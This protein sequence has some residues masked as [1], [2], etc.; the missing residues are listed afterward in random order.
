MYCR[1]RFSVRLG[2]QFIFEKYF[3]SI[4]QMLKTSYYFDFKN[5]DLYM[6]AYDDVTDRIFS[7]SMLID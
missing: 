5:Q 2:N 7:H 6:Q 3:P 4:N 1:Y